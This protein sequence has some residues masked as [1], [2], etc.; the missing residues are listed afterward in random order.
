M[1]TGSP[2]LDQLLSSTRMRTTERGSFSSLPSGLPAHPCWCVN[3]CIGPGCKWRMGEQTHSNNRARPTWAS[4]EP[5]VGQPHLLSNKLKNQIMQLKKE[6]GC[7]SVW[8]GLGKLR[9]AAGMSRMGHLPP[10]NDTQRPLVSKART[11]A[12]LLF[13]PLSPLCHDILLG[14]RKPRQGGTWSPAPCRHSGSWLKKL[15]SQML[16]FA[17][18]AHL[19]SYNKTS[20]SAYITLLHSPSNQPSLGSNKEMSEVIEEYIFS[21]EMSVCA[22]AEGGGKKDIEECLQLCTL[23]QCNICVG[24][25]IWNVV[26]NNDIQLQKSLNITER[27]PLPLAV[28]KIQGF[29]SH[30]LHHQHNVDPDCVKPC[31]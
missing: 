16:T 30:S 17:T 28:M 23:Q 31:D 26:V 27:I 6:A 22:L 19:W 5:G 24:L 8:K 29:S 12:W 20:A 2:I 11:A 14:L 10:D 21:P 3:P 4:W 7:K 13:E 1:A 9:G 25:F 15:Q 18:A